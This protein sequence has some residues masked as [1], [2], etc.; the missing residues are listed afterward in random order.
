MK[1]VYDF[2]KQFGKN[3]NN[4]RLYLKESFVE[5]PKEVFQKYI[6]LDEDDCD[7]FLPVDF[8]DFCKSFPDFWAKIVHMWLSQGGL[9]GKTIEEIRR[10]KSPDVYNFFTDEDVQKYI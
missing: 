2:L 3:W 1:D 9:K 10:T 8:Q 6:V 7:E 5:I 4:K